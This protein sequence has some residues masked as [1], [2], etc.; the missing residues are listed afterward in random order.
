MENKTLKDWQKIVIDYIESHDDFAHTESMMGCSDYE[1]N[2]LSRIRVGLPSGE[3]HTFLSAKIACSYPTLFIYKDMQHWREICQNG[4]IHEDDLHPKTSLVSS[5][6]ISH[7]IFASYDK[8]NRLEE[9][10]NKFIDKK[11]I[12]ID[13]ATEIT[14]SFPRVV[15][16]IF[17]VVNPEQSIVLLG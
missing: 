17:S 12:L 4:Q 15:E 11:V 5:F 3:G 7:D 16:W 2:M 13:D 9:L 6:E 1:R 10:K 14:E 8:S